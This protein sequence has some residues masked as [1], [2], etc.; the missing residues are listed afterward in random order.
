[1]SRKKNGFTLLE[2]LVVIAILATLSALVVP[3]FMGARERARDTQRKSDLRQ[4]QKALELYKMDQNPPVY[5]TALPTPGDLWNDPNTGVTYMNKFPA[6]PLVSSDDYEYTYVRHA[7]DDLRYYLTAC[8][9]N[10]ADIDGI[11][12]LSNPCTVD[13]CGQE[14]TCPNN[15]HFTLTEP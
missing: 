10:K 12:D 11:S 5:P 7:T 2:L 6:D 13:T 1:M 14:I 8:L 3:N 15:I 4:I 9:E